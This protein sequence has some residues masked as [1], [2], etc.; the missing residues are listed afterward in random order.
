M[1]HNILIHSTVDTHLGSF[2]FVAITNSA[3]MNIISEQVGNLCWV[4]A[5]GY[6]K[7]TF[8]P[9]GRDLGREDA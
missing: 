4:Y 1:F 3:T 8:G 9:E 2:Q 6:K 7:R 5:W